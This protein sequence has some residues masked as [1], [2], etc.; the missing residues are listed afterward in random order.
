MSHDLRIP[1]AAIL[2]NAESLTQSNLSKN[3]RHEFYGE[4]RS[5]VD[6]VRGLNTDSA[7]RAELP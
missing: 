4:I 6:Q 2:A 7:R 5:S 1:L 3:E